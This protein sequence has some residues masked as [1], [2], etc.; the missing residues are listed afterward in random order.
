MKNILTISKRDTSQGTLLA[1]A[2][3]LFY[4]F[5]HRFP[6]H[7]NKNLFYEIL[8]KDGLD[9]DRSTVDHLHASPFWLVDDLSSKSEYPNPIDTFIV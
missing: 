1:E 4:D 9:L 7:G 8:E 2:L 6:N 3:L 5:L